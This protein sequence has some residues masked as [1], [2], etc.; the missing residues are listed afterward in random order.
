MTIKKQTT[1]QAPPTKVSILTPAWNRR[2][3]LEILY[4][5]LLAQTSR[6]F[7][8]LVA[9]DGSNDG[10]LDFLLNAKRESNF[11]IHVISS[12][13]RVGKTV[14]DNIL[15]KSVATEYYL[16]CDSDDWL[17]PNA[18]EKLVNTIEVGKYDLVVAMNIDLTGALQSGQ[19][20]FQ[21]VESCEAEWMISQLGGDSTILMRTKNTSMIS[22]SEVDFVVTESSS[23]IN[24]LK[25]LT[26]RHGSFFAKVMDRGEPN[27]VSFSKG[28]KYCRGSAHSLRA[29]L[30]NRRYANSPQIKNRPRIR[31]LINLAR[32]S[33]NGDLGFNYYFDSLIDAPISMTTKVFC[34]LL[35]AAVSLRDR[36][37]GGLVKTHLE[38][39]KNRIHATIQWHS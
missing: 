14:L 10:S 2:R 16:N 27:S 21:N 17:L 11:K 12:D 5:S 28:I 25:G 24:R 9:D 35:G 26:A 3:G 32:Y 19:G 22:H 36:Y 38:F 39:E 29:D 20:E 1:A 18:I 6:S 23:Y 8:W 34:G 7:T 15:L 31:E 33:L 30:A 37:S 13:R 4:K